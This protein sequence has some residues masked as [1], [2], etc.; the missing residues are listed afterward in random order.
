MREET[1]LDFNKIV[2]QRHDNDDDEDEH[3]V[4]ETK[5]DGIIFGNNCFKRIKID[6]DDEN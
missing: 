2:R 4:R 5:L 1:R 3:K 6:I